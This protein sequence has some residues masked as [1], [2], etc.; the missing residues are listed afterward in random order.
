MLEFSLHLLSLQTVIYMMRNFIY[1]L[2]LSVTF[3]AC[4]KY[5]QVLKSPDLEH[6]F[7]MA[8]QYYE[9]EQYFKALPIFDELNTLYRGTAKA[10][11]VYYYLAYTHYGLSEH[12]IAAYHFRTFSLTFP[13]SKHREEMAYMNAY[14]YYLESPTHSLDASNTYRAIEELQLFVDVFPESNRVKECNR[15]ID[16]LRAKLEMKS[17]EIAKLYFDTGNYKAAITA[18]NNVTLDYPDTDYSEEIH[19]LILD[20]NHLLASNSVSSKQKERWSNT[21]SA[22]HQFVDKFE[23]SKK[24]KDAESIYNKANKQ[25][26]KLN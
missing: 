25:L 2:L 8:K 20:A 16:D 5:Q 13:S 1:I 6:K 23:S 10:E 17:F 12:L 26:E 18:L 11:E 4:S 3:S 15:L 7:K 9:E 22:Y 24:L 19:F 21:V 14:C